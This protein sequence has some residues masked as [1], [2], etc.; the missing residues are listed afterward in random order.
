MKKILAFALILIIVFPL[1]NAHGIDESQYVGTWIQEQYNDS[2]GRYTVELLRLTED[3]QAYY[4]TQAFEPGEIDFGRQAAK[5]WSA[6]G[7]GIHIIL[8]ENTETDA[9]ILDDGRLGLKL[10][11]NAYSPF[12][13]ISFLSADT[14]SAF[15]G[16]VL[17]P[18]MYEVGI[19]LPEGNYYFEG[20]E[21]RYPSNVHVYPSIEKTRALDV[22]QE[23][24]G[25]GYG[26]N[27]GSTITGKVILKNGWILEI[28]Q[29]PAII[30]Q[31]TGLIN[32]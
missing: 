24:S 15:E 5:T 30:H 13:K 2:T 26:Y 4:I 6:K 12:Q 25:F 20:V 3:H 8:G 29:G 23:V 10:A 31:F 16:I 32:H 14:I 7:N 19:D 21:G 22:I 9:I 27:S 11:G 17:E 18:G 1:G 28:V